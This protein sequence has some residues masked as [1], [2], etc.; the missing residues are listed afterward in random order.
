MIGSPAT[1]LEILA[2]YGACVAAA[3]GAARFAGRPFPGR[4]LAV[5]ALLPLLFVAPGLL[6]R[7]T[8][9]PA[10]HAWLT[11][12]DP[13]AT[14]TTVWTDDLARQFAPWA[15]ATALAWRAGELPLRNRWNGCGTPLAANGSSAAFFPPT[16]LGL[17]LP[18]SD[19]FTFWAALRLFICLA[20]TFLWLT[21]LDVSPAPAVFGA[22]ALAFSLSMTAWLAFPQ[23]AAL[24]LWPWALWCIERLRDPG[25]A[26]R[27]LALLVAILTA[28]PLAGHLETVA[29][30]AAFAAL[31]LAVRWALG[32]R[33]GAG[34]VARR[35]SGAAAVAVALSAFALLP[36]VLA[37][38]DSNRLALVTRPFWADALSWRPHWPVWPAGLFAPAFPRVAGDAI[39]AQML[40]D[41]PA[42]FPEIALGHFGIVALAI[43]ALMVRPG[44]RRSPAALALLVPAV[45][46]LGAAIGA[47]PFAELAALPPALSRM[48]P[49]RY[50]TWFAF[51]GAALAAFELDR[52][53]RDLPRRRSAAL[54]AIGAWTAAILL[55]GATYAGF[56]ARYRAASA[57]APQRHAYLLAAGAAAAAILV[58]AAT[59]YGPPRWR[60]AA[61]P[62]VTVVAAAELARQGTRVVRWSDPALLYP[63]TPLVRFLRER[64]RPFRIA[65]E[66]GALFPNVGILARLEDARTHDP[67][68]RRDYVELLDVACGYDPRPYFKQLAKPDCA[69][70]AALN[71]R[72]FVAPPGRPAPSARWKT[73]YTGE[74]GVVFEDPAALPRVFAPERARVVRR[75]VSRLLPEPATRA[76]GVPYATLLAGP[77][78]SRD[79]VVLAAAGS[80]FLPS[81]GR[82]E[83]ADYRER[84]NEVS[85]RVRTDPSGRGALLVTSLVEDGGWRAHDEKGKA[86]PTGRANGPFLALQAPPG[87]H[88]VRLEYAP[89]GFRAG[90]AVSAGTLL[91]LVGIRRHRSRGSPEDDPEADG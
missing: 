14:P 88:R 56:A 37:I 79:A 9:I 68:E 7:K 1:S 19:A 6:A 35:V 72:Y 73:A 36:Q 15:E 82:A 84:T 86:I 21:E 26:G 57:V 75:I 24:G 77:D 76:Y 51:A 2:L 89:P 23:A 47:W 28:M 62:L 18:L 44:G 90:G 78:G 53:L 64:G 38:R 43:A 74:D 40:A 66:G 22:V 5:L 25:A 65:G 71:V 45:L 81:A 39:T 46:G 59:A 32:D 60:V 87:E 58:F 31:W 11:R 16:L 48:F 20:G 4:S 42:S 33:R 55:A 80:A 17:L 30:L 49:L 54:W 69:A 63:E 10:D 13:R 3:A 52:L 8:L 91:L 27:A 34:A 67:V 70:L 85:F 29:S 50:L 61:A 12:P 41:A 83:I